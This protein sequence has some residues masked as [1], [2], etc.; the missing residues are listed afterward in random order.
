MNDYLQ[1]RGVAI[2][3]YP[4]LRLRY[5]T[6]DALSVACSALKLPEHLA[7]TF[8][9][10]V[11][12]TPEFAQNWKQV[13]EEQK[14]FCTQS[15]TLKKPT[16]LLSYLQDRE[17]LA[18]WDEKYQIYLSAKETL[19]RLSQES[20]QVKERIHHLYRCLKDLKQ[21]QAQLQK[22]KGVHFRSV[23]EWTQEEAARREAFG[24]RE[25]EIMREKE[26]LRR[27]LW[28]TRN[29]GWHIERGA[30][31]Q[32]A[33]QTLRQIEDETELARLRLVRNALLT[34]EG[35]PHT[36]HRPS[37]WWLPMVDASG[38]WFR[39]IAETAECYLEPL[40]S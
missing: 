3:N 16:A 35:L 23:E 8:G 18:G 31:A 2:H 36:A 6:W 13:V 25:A 1:S 29:Q 9:Q 11:I 12:T 26:T 30:E 4:I 7:S 39:E 5:H 32:Q 20:V 37:A 22:A 38:K 24:E 10:S 28:H 19:L 21:E 27:Q 17:P 34:L 15:L 33:R 14:S 40:L